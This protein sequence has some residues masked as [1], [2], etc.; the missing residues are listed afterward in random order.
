MGNGQWVM[1]D[2]QWVMGD[3]QENYLPTPN[4]SAA[5]STSD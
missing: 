4:T 5:L 1:G 2:G 3:G